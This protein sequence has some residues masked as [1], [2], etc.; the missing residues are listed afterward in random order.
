[1]NIDGTWPHMATFGVAVAATLV[2]PSRRKLLG[3]SFHINPQ[4]VLYDSLLGAVI[5]PFGLIMVGSL[6]STEVLQEALKSNSELMAVGG[7]WGIVA[8]ISD[9]L[10]K[11][12]PPKS[13]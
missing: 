8:V 11:P 9:L 6:L 3:H 7:F 5:V 2:R 1:M 13:G 12:E 10:R 4:E